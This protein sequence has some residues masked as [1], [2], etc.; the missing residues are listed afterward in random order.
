MRLLPQPEPEPD[1]P[2]SPQAAPVSPHV[3]PR[4]LPNRT[5]REARDTHNFSRSRHYSLFSTSGNN[6][7]HFRRPLAP[8]FPHDVRVLPLLL[9]GVADAR[10]RPAHAQIKQVK[11]RLGPTIVQNA[12]P[13]MERPEGSWLG[14]S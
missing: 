9:G 7:Q 11:L 14:I 13:R 1:A 10:C 12:S 8:P 5:L 3:P 2:A 6:T 4:R